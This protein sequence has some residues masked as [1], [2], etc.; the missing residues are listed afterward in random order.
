MDTITQVDHHAIFMSYLVQ[1]YGSYKH[2]RKTTE[3]APMVTSGSQHTGDVQAFLQKYF[4]NEK[5]GIDVAAP[6]HTIQ[7]SDRF[8]LAEA[9]CDVK[10]LTDEQCYNAWC[11]ARLLDEEFFGARRANTQ[12]NLPH[13]L[14]V[15]F[16]SIF[17]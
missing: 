9:H 1:L 17:P 10:P 4:G 13:D 2:V 15:Y 5:D 11:I 16:L 7:T 8:G 12:V 14:A 6:M 3:P